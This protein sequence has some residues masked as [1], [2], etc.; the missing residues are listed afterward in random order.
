MTISPR[1]LLTSSACIHAMFAFVALWVGPAWAADE[2]P[3][4]AQAAQVRI[5][6]QVAEN[7]FG[8][9][10]NNV[11]EGDED[12][13]VNPQAPDP[14]GPQVLEF[15][16]STLLHGTLTS[17]DAASGL[18][19]WHRTDT[20]AP[21]TFP[22]A[23]IGR[24]T[25]HA[26]AKPD[27]K[28]HATVKLTGGDWLAADVTGLADKKIQ[29]KLG[30][31][32][33]IAIDRDAV[34]WIYFSKSAAPECFDGPTSFAGWVSGGGWTFR[35]GALRALTPAAIG[36]EF[37]ALPDQTEYFLEVDQGAAGHAFTLVLHSQN[38][39]GRGRSTGTVQLMFRGS[40]L[41]MW[42]QSANNNMKTD[43][44][45]LTKLLPG[46][47]EEGAAGKKPVQ[48]RVLEDFSGG[49]LIA[50]VNGRKVADWKLEKGESGENR[51][52]VSFQPQGWNSDSEQV[53]SQFR[54][55]PW[56]GRV[57]QDDA[58]AAAAQTDLVALGEGEAKAGTIESFDG[59]HL[60]LRTGDG[61]VEVPRAKV[62][63]LRFRRADHPPDEDP[64]VGRVRLA[65]R[66]E[67][68]VA[69]ISF[70][71]GKFILRT[72]FSG[73]LTLAA[74]ALRGLDFS[75][76][77]WTAPKPGDELVFHNGDHLRGELESAADGHKLR[78]R[79]TGSDT[80]A[81]IDPAGLAGIVLAAPAKQPA[82]KRGLVARLRNGDLLGGALIKLDAENLVLD[83]APAGQF[84]ITRDHVQALYFSAD[85]KLPVLDGA[86]RMDAWMGLENDNNN[87]Y[88]R[89]GTATK[90]GLKK[91]QQPSAWR[92]FDGAFT[93]TPATFGRAN[94][95]RTGSLR[96]A[97]DFDAMPQVVELAFDV[98]VPKPP[99]AFT[100][101]LFFDEKSPG[102]LLQLY[103]AGIY[104]YDAGARQQMRAGGQQQLQF[105]D[106][107]KA[108]ARQRHIQV[109]ADR[110][111]GR[112]TIMIDGA[113]IGQVGS[114]V[115]APPRNLGR[116]VILTNSVPGPCTFANLWVGPWN[117]QTPG[118]S[119][120]PDALSHTILL[121]NGD[122]TRGTVESITAEEA[123]I[124]SE[125]GAIEIP[126]A[127]LIA[128][129]FGG[130]P[131]ARS[132]GTRLRLADWGALTA[133]SFRVEKDE[134]IGQSDLLGEFKLPRSAVREIVFA[135]PEK[136]AAE[137][138]RAP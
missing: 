74:A 38:I 105:G 88:E 62:V 87:P 125:A 111:L 14:A 53:I 17:L 66:G 71:Q 77:G 91:T 126:T 78:W 24:L 8:L 130:A 19:T 98:I 114:K 34:E 85:G 59:E 15:T 80:L 70:R 39:I 107:V 7:G 43:S 113:V 90:P 68:D 135:A 23:N 108:K 21:F 93:Y 64:P 1:S 131:G 82:T 61:V 103:A 127:R 136:P 110:R 58:P 25:L 122:E 67:F 99:V 116:N 69:G 120:A 46:L 89:T 100:A 75:R 56:D 95:A 10:V 106:K 97:A 129:D 134:V 112:L 121:A 137:K 26:G 11:D 65:Q 54:V 79:L 5:I 73:E 117:G 42:A 47:A 9:F 37:E 63:M 72:N 48:F 57:P 41:Q 132:R 18:L 16:D 4:A 52:G 60:K 128:L 84:T 44:V 76:N 119:P 124:E 94:V 3:A 86:A 45:N 92:S 49:R 33:V 101:Q 96:L 2:K 83:C 138:K 13:A 31:G 40:E 35:D 50:F 22:L 123:K 27:A 32:S 55:G 29:L 51:G 30:D 133:K 118:I 36:R 104:I 20:S 102:Y 109:L 12:G 115:G 81:E 28:I 6:R